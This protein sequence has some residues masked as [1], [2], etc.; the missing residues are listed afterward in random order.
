MSGPAA[1]PKS[2]LSRLLRLSRITVFASLA[3]VVSCGSN[4]RSGDHRP[5]SAP[6]P[7][8]LSPVKDR[9]AEFGRLFCAALQHPDGRQNKWDACATYIENVPHDIAPLRGAIPGSDRYR[10]LI[11]PGFGSQ[12]FAGV[13]RVFSD[14]SS[15]LATHG[16]KSE[17]CN[18][19]TALGSSQQNGDRIA[20]YVKSHLSGA[21]RRPY[22]AV[23]YS[24]GAVDIL[25]A[26]VDHSLN[27]S[28]IAAVI[29][30]AGAFAGS[31]VVD[32]K[33]IHGLAPVTAELGMR[34]QQLHLRERCDVGDNRGLLS[35]R[36]EV[37][38]KFLRDH[39]KSFREGTFP[40]VYS[41]VAVSDEKTTSRI[42]KGNW[43]RLAAFDRKQDGQIIASDAIF[44]R[45]VFLGTL[46]A[47]HLAVALP[48]EYAKRGRLR[49]PAIAWLRREVD[50]TKDSN[51]C[52]HDAR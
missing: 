52:H 46:K 3:G 48:F 18:T 10:V 6:A 17:Y 39:S 50:K 37:R 40:T 30:L 51:A 12:C 36:R 45:G 19:V 20:K 49:R 11:V 22:I 5:S 35:V 47:D 14:A 27:K 42:F 13:A 26:I 31:R 28:Q 4:D 16:V 15:H 38:Q 9:Q 44:P 7:I 43:R 32:D 33:L 2:I 29:S 25:H 8:E 1:V 34:L 41:V 24:K 21:D 23:G